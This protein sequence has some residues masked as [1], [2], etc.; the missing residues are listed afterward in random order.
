MWRMINVPW[1]VFV[2]RCGCCCAAFA[3]LVYGFVDASH[4]ENHTHHGIHTQMPELGPDHTTCTYHTLR[5]RIVVPAWPCPALPCTELQILG[6]FRL[7]FASDSD[8]F[9]CSIKGRV[10]KRW[11]K[12]G[13]LKLSKLVAGFGYY[14]QVPLAGGELKRVGKE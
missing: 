11:K 6:I 2:C 4:T 13:N 10:L 7:I 14:L 9:L 8:N 5:I 1:H 12:G 3:C